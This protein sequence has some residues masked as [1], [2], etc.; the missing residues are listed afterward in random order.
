[1]DPLTVG[2]L[3]RIYQQEII[4]RAA[5]DGWGTPAN[6]DLQAILDEQ[7]EYKLWRQPHARSRLVAW[8][9]RLGGLV[10]SGI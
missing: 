7:K 2:A 3:A 8:R 5:N 9:S 1:M 4:D 10:A 6:K